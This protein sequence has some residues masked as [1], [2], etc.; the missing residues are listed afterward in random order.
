MTPA[1]RRR[2]VMNEWRT[3]QGERGAAGVPEVLHALEHIASRRAASVA[4]GERLRLGARDLR[5][6]QHRAISQQRKRLHGEPPASGDVWWEQISAIAAGWGIVTAQADWTP[7]ERGRDQ[8][9]AGEPAVRYSATEV[10]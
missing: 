2:A 9:P 5:L 8:P 7:M 6:A 10:I 4:E 1:E 3:N